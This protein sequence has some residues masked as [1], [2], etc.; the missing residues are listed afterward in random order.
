MTPNGITW[1]VRIQS[2]KA[3]CPSDE[4]GEAPCHQLLQGGLHPHGELQVQFFHQI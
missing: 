2:F 3:L 1:G 4:A